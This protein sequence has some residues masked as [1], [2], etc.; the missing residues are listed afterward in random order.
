VT[1]NPF[2]RIRARKFGNVVAC[3]AAMAIPVSMI[4]VSGGPA[5]AAGSIDVTNAE[6]ACSGVTGAIKFSPPLTSNAAAGTTTVSS[7]LK[8]SDCTTN[9]DL[10]SVVGTGVL[11]ISGGHPAGN[12]C[13]SLADEFLGSGTLAIKWKASEKL[14]SGASEINV[15]SLEALSNDEDNPSLL[16]GFPGPTGGKIPTATGSFSSPFDKHDGGVFESTVPTASLIA[17]CEGKRGLKSIP[18]QSD[19]EYAPVSLN[20]PTDGVW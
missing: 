9:T 11:S 20:M 5:A 1:R 3:L 4:V 19:I 8:L 14:S 6:V 15:N 7:H 16:I 17:K 2:Q 12:Q 10:Q 18:L 13:S